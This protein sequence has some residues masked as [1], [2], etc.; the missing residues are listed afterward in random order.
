MTTRK[1]ST[2]GNVLSVISMA[3][4]VLGGGDGVEHDKSMCRFM[5]CLNSGGA[6]SLGALISGH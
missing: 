5:L 3:P 6:Y 4:K 2:N 1:S